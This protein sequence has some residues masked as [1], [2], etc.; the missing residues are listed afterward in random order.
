ME[1]GGNGA[2]GPGEMQTQ[3]EGKNHRTTRS[4]Q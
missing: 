2:A 3:A 4:L 1:L